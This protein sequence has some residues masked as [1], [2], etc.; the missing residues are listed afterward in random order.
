MQRLFVDVIVPIAI[1]RTLTYEVPQ[2]LQP[3]VVAG[4]RVI[5]QVG[6]QKIYSGI[7]RRVHTNIPLYSDIKEVQSVLDDEPIVNERQFQ[8]WE[9][10]AEY[11]MCTIG[12]VMNCALPASLKLQSETTVIL[13][14]DYP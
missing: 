11:Y 7:V 14:P 1:P 3:S 10:I 12:E 8:L 5:I 6:K 4:K 2:N 13:N 9:W